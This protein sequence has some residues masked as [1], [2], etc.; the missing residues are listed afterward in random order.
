MEQNNNKN[1]IDLG[2]GR[3]TFKNTT[4]VILNDGKLYDI[5]KDIVYLSMSHF[6]RSK[7]PTF[8]VTSLDA[9]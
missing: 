6:I 7:C 2:L 9:I 4:V 1:E 3:V 8:S 5:N